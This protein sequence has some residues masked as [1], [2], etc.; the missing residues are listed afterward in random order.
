MK[1]ILDFCKNCSKT[2]TAL[3]GLLV[4]LPSVINA[5]TDIYV[6]WQGLPIGNQEKINSRLFQAH[7]KENPI[8]S[9]QLMVKG[10]T[11][12]SAMTLDVFQ[13]GDVFINYGENVQWFPYQDLQLA[14]SGFS[15]ISAAYADWY[16]EPTTKQSN[17]TLEADS[18]KVESRY[19]SKTEIERVR[20]LSDG[21]KIKQV[22]NV[23][24]GRIISTEYIA[25]E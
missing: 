7:F 3:L 21:S 19:I 22:I 6:A 20:Y 1:Q 12:A 15:F 25:A 4:V 23:N 2:I 9:Q 11:G 8:N 10:Q 24:T 14:E 13:N 17:Q 18:V 5:I 16:V